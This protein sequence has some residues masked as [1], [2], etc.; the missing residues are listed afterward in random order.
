MTDEIPARTTVS[1]DYDT[2]ERLDD[3][4]DPGASWD[5]RVNALLD[6]YEAMLDEWDEDP[7]DADALPENVATAEDLDGLRE[8]LLGQIPG[9][10]AR[11]LDERLGHR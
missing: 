5:D 11:E 9:A 4:A 10:V 1:L 8:D 6:D 2:K 7:L 3:L